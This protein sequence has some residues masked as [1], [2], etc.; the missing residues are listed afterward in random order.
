MGVEHE[1]RWKARDSFVLPNWMW[2][3]HENLRPSDEA[4]L[5]HGPYRPLSDS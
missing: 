1:L 3:A 5:F 4:I 2:H